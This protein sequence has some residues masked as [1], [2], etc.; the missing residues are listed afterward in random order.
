MYKLLTNKNIAL[1]WKIMATRAC[2]LYWTIF[3][4][5]FLLVVGEAVTRLIKKT[6][7]VLFRGI[8]C[9]YEYINIHMLAASQIKKV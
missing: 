2:T 3:E 5:I 8:G 6:I 9:L 7:L 4:F 1:E